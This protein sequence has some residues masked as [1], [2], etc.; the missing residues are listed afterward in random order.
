MVAGGSRGFTRREGGGSGGSDRAARGGRAGGG[1]DRAAAARGPEGGRGV[2]GGAGRGSG[3]GGDLGVGA[4]A[5]S[6][7]VGG[8]A[9]AAAAAGNGTTAVGVSE[10]AG[11]QYRVTRR[12]ALFLILRTA[13]YTRREHGGARGN[14]P[15]RDAGPGQPHHTLMLRGLEPTVTNDDVRPPRPPRQRC[16]LFACAFLRADRRCS[17]AVCRAQLLAYFANLGYNLLPVRAGSLLKCG[18]V[19]LERLLVSDV[20]AF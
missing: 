5:A 9:A 11:L 14:D 1:C 7:G 12:Y 8:A 4:A 17:A 2:R 16:S 6:G 19:I 20:L 10:T 15:Y 3:G 13:R 18:R